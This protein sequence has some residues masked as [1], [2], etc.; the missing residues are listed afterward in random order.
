MNFYLIV[1]GSRDYNN[2]NEM[3]KILDFLLQNQKDKNIV[4]VSGGAKGADRFAEI[5]AQNHNYQIQIIKAEW[6]K[7]GKSAGYL[8]NKKMHEFIK[9]KPHKGCV[10]FWN[11]KSKGTQHNFSLAK[12]YNIPLRVFSSVKH[13]FLHF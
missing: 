2:Y 9:D 5:Y 4:I 6:N 12:K 11:E 7:Y 13:K 8:R 1:V 3:S 10:C